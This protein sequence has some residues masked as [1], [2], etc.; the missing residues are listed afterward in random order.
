MERWHLKKASECCRKHEVVAGAGKQ[1][2]S[3]DEWVPVLPG[4]QG[5]W[6]PY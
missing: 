1:H 3:L 4:H 5:G 2:L 6:A